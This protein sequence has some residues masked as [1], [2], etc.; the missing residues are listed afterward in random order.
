MSDRP[1][2]TL[3]SLAPPV[4]SALAGAGY[5]TVQDLLS[6][7]TPEQLSKDLNIPLPASQAVFSAA[8]GPSQR[9][10]PMTQSAAAMM[11]T[12]AKQ[13]S[14]ACPPLDR[15]LGGG[16]KRGFILEINGPPGS[17]KEQMAATAVR[18][19]VECDQQ[20][21]FV[22]M[23]NMVLPATIKRILMNS[24]TAD[25]DGMDL[26]RY[27]AFHTTAEFVAFV[28]SLP[29]YLEANPSTALLVLNSLAFPFQPHTIKRFAMLDKLKQVLARACASM[30]L[31]VIITSQL[32]TKM[33]EGNGQPGSAPPGSKSVMIPS[34]RDSDFPPG[35]TY[36]V[37]IVPLTRTTGVIRL[38]SSP[39]HV[40]SRGQPA[41]EE[42]YQRIRGMIS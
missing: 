22:D 28:R 31:T 36:R 18:T 25:P 8:A 33:L 38:L 16:L 15:L 34:F 30:G 3:S 37:I 27:L 42:P 2:S 9:S 1:L 12:T 11:G 5:E 24:P 32:T 41:R 23:Q 17:G 26:V 39:T 7:S 13:Y 20:V 40:P 29:A 21:L 35:R 10:L 4:L 6:N 19:F 14:T